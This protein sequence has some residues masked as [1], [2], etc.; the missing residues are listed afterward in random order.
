MTVSAADLV[1]VPL[2][3][4]LN[5]QELQELAASLATHLR[6]GAQG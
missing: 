5:E 1:A 3:E 4:S 2:F 6:A